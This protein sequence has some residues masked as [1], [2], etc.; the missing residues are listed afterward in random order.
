MSGLLF[1][2]QSFITAACFSDSLIENDIGH[3]QGWELV[4]VNAVMPREVGCQKASK[5][6]EESHITPVTDIKGWPHLQLAFTL[7]LHQITQQGALHWPPWLIC[8]LLPPPSLHIPFMCCC[9]FLFA[10]SARW[11]RQNKLSYPPT[12]PCTRHLFTPENE[13]CDE[14]QLPLRKLAVDSHLISLPR[15]DNMQRSLSHLSS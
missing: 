14:S 4:N 9:S 13:V 8:F 12:Q 7:L 2:P 15:V 3:M 5:S 10:T 11:F 6:R 1:S